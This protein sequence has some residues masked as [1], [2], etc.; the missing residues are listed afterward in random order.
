MDMVMETIPG[1]KGRK[2]SENSDLQLIF[3]RLHKYLLENRRYTGRGLNRN[4]LAAAIRTN[5]K[6]LTRAV[7][8]FADGKTLGEFIDSLRMEYA[9]LLLLNSPHY[10]IDAIARECGATSRSAFYRLFRKYCGCTPCAY[11]ENSE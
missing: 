7:C 8:R 4:N 10:T 9:K 3:V 6:Y 1:R 11:R 2:S 5:E